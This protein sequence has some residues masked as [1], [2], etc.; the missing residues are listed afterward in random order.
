VSLFLHG[1]GH[2]HPPNE[3]TNRFLEELD[4][5]TSEA[6]IL[7]RVG[8]RSRRTVLPLDYIRETRNRDL[9]A[10]PEAAELGNAE[11]AA[12]AG[13]LALERAGI[14][15]EQVGLVVSGSSAP[16][17]LCPAEACSIAAALGVDAPAWDVNSACSSFGV[18]LHTLASMRPEALPRFALVVSVDAFTKVTD[19]T[20]RATAVLWGDAAAAAVVS[21]TEPGRARVL[22]THVASDPRGW[23]K[24]RV[25]RTGHFLQDGRAVQMFVIRRTQEGYEAL[26][27][28]CGEP[29]RALHFVG[30]QANLRA[31]QSVCGRAG[32]PDERH[33]SNVELFGNTGCPGAP[34]VVSQA[35]EKWEAHDDVAVVVVG[36]GLTWARVLLRWGGA[37]EAA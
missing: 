11:L 16:D 12:R 29:G 7:D 24:V 23:R 34:T 21:P 37:Q 10:A 35:W 8:I 14:G 33:H 25:P 6:W 22:G 18:G 5:G 4:I 32:I 3:I 31:L 15:P 30:H 27:E 19:Y 1:L 28:T 26:R 20:D 17:S 13:R 2:A 9:R 36:G